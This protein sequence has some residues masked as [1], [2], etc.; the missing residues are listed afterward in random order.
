MVAINA[1]DLPTYDI[2]LTPFVPLL[3]DGNNHTITLD[4]SSDE[5]DH[6]GSHFTTDMRL[7]KLIFDAVV[8]PNWYLSGN[9]QIST[10][11]SLKPTTGKITSYHAPMWA[12]TTHSATPGPI[13]GDW[14]FTVVATH[15]LRIEA[16]IISGDS[17]VNHVVWMQ[18]LQFSNIQSYLDNTVHQVCTQLPHWIS[19]IASIVDPHTISQRLQHL[20]SQ[21]CSCCQR[22]D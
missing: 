5:P 8:G 11:K 12:S 21:S 22:S 20:Y 15:N 2:D 6:C 16:D 10:S 3:T 1:Y 17:E 19:L 4:I 18:D 14:N 7:G 13:N 9:V